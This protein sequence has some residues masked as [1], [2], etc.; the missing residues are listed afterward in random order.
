MK[1]KITLSPIEYERGFITIKY[2][3]KPI[4][5]KLHEIK[6]ISDMENIF[7]M[8]HSTYKEDAQIF[9]TIYSGRKPRGFDKYMNKNRSRRFL[10]VNDA[11]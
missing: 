7:D 9:V 8:L 5:S 2:P 4:Y 11:K 3:H 10:R 6:N 1:T